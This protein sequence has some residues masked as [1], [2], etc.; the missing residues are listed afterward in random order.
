[1]YMRHQYHTYRIWPHYRIDRL[2]FF[3]FFFKIT[4]NPVVK[5]L[6]NGGTNFDRSAED[7]IR[8]TMPMLFFFFL[9][10]ILKA[11]AREFI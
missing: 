9:I 10:S 7:F 6:P 11:Y 2:A 5:F 4:E 8:V 3:F 1:M